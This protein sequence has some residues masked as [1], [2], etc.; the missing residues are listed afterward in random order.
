MRLYFFQGDWIGMS[1]R[2]RKRVIPLA[3]ISGSASVS[4]SE[5]IDIEDATNIWLYII[6]SGNSHCRI[7]VADEA[8]GEST[9]DWYYA[10]AGSGNPAT[11]G[12]FAVISQKAYK[13]PNFAYSE[14]TFNHKKMRI[15]NA[16]D[17]REWTGVFVEIT[18]AVG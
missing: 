1:A 18:K 16:T 8:V 2:R 17:S 12:G 11:F 4:W 10:G 15:G 14:G 13:I 6:S 9:T 3:D 5:E 7:Q